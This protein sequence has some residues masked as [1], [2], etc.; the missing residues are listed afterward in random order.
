MA[1]EQIERS[2]GMKAIILIGG[3]APAV[4]GDI[5]T[6]LY[7]HYPLTQTD[8]YDHPATRLESRKRRTLPSPSP[9]KGTRRFTTNSFIGYVLYIV[10]DLFLFPK[11][12]HA[13][14]HIAKE[15]IAQRK[16]LSTRPDH[17]A[18]P[19]PSIPS[20]PADNTHSTSDVP[21]L[22]P[23]LPGEPSLTPE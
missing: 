9:G 14:E 4:V 16:D 23:S 1:L 13:H 20:D 18:T 12:P 17:T 22:P 19:N 21:T 8:A 7:V 6:H 5:N 10:S 11:E 3:L 2:T 15:E